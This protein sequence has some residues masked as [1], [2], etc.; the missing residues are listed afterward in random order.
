MAESNVDVNISPGPAA[1]IAA[2]LAS[3]VEATATAAAG[4]LKLC[5]VAE[6]NQVRRLAVGKGC[7][8]RR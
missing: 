1:D 4:V 2:L 7:I 5:A 3:G 8:G 6:G